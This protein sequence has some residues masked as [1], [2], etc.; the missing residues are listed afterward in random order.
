MPPAPNSKKALASQTLFRGLEIVD[1]VAQGN[2]TMQEI[3]D[4]TGIA[5][6]TA[7]RLASALVQIRYLYFEPRKGYRLGSKLVELGF[8]AYR[9][10][11]LNRQARESLDWLAAQ[12]LDTV[13]LA[14]LDG[15]HVVYLDKIS[16]QRSIEVTSRIGGRKPICTT[17]VGKALI[18]EQGREQ[19][20]EHF[21]REQQ[22]CRIKGTCETWL[23]A[24]DEYARVGYALD[25]GEDAPQIRCVAAPIRDGSG[26]IIAAVS[27][28]ST[29][30]Y[31]NDR[32][33]LELAPLVQQAAAQIS[34]RLGSPAP[35]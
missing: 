33:L 32:R 19:W 14:V 29:V 3:A 24:M 25:L 13:H 28:T 18:L 12:S 20:Q 9:E 11:D 17:G 30:D 6:S 7:H 26:R 27:V 5:F 2:R 31:T 8:L 21:R 23:A 16:G 34:M 35:Q 10:S 15:E 22:A 4:A 1:A